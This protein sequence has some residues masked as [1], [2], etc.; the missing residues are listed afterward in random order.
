MNPYTIMWLIVFAVMLVI[1]ACTSILVC[2]WFMP[3]ALICA[4]LASLGV[5]SLWQYISFFVISIVLLAVFRKPFGKFIYSRKKDT[6]TNLDVIIGSEARVEEE[7]DNFKGVGRVVVGSQSWAARSLN[8]E[9]IPVGSKV[10]VRKIEGVK[11]ICEYI[12]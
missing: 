9:V 8:G 7:I 2:I 5:P 4:L 12:Q 11:L 10:V 3:T 6:L 1:E